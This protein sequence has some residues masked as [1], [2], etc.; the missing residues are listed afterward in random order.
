MDPIACYVRWL[1]AKTRSDRRE[2]ASDYNAWVN[3]GGFRAAF[4]YSANSDLMA[5][6][7]RLSEL[8]VYG[9]M[10]RADGTI[11]LPFRCAR[12]LSP[13]PVGKAVRS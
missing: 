6:V 9:Y 7:D 12:R 11:G 8:R 13:V 5:V 4:A 10:R 2:A 3:R 1:E